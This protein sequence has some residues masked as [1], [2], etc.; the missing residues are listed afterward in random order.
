MAD[1]IKMFRARAIDRVSAALPKDHQLAEAV[2]DQVLT[3]EPNL[4]N[5]SRLS[6]ATDGELATLVD[7]Y[8]DD[9]SFLGDLKGRFERSGSMLLQATQPVE[10]RTIK[11]E[12]ARRPETSAP[13]AI[14]MFPEGFVVPEGE[15]ANEHRLDEAVSAEDK[16]W[17]ESFSTKV[18]TSLEGEAGLDLDPNDLA[19]VK[20]SLDAAVTLTKAPHSSKSALAAILAVPGTILLAIAANTIHEVMWSE[21]GQEILDFVA[22]LTG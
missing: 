22:R 7:L 1:P 19:E 16:A 10:V 4:T 18:S 14:A 5:A 3:P 15:S 2:L 9:D 17:L 6:G 13:G 11:T 12:A 8:Y 20:I 21:F